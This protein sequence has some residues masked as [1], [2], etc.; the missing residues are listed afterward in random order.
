MVYKK[1]G[2]KIEDVLK[3]HKIEKKIRKL[4]KKKFAFNA[5]TSI[6][7]SN[8]QVQTYDLDGIS[9]TVYV[10]YPLQIFNFIGPTEREIKNK[11]SRLER[12]LGI[13]INEVSD[14]EKRFTG[15]VV[16]EN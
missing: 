12:K 13:K 4:Y 11:K 16:T 2:L 3:T 10:D 6:G 5:P 14:V 7:E 8:F 9:L 15:K 1:F